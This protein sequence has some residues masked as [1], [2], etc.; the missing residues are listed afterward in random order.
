MFLHKN[1]TSHAKN[2]LTPENNLQRRFQ[3]IH[4][5]RL[6]QNCTISFQWIVIGIFQNFPK[7]SKIFSKTS[8]AILEKSFAMNSLKP[9][10]KIIFRSQNIFCMGSMVFMQKHL[11]RKMLLSEI[12]S[13][14]QIEVGAPFSML[15]FSNFLTF[16]K[17]F[18]H[19]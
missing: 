11:R 6:F 4:S 9:P 3:R 17:P 18:D 10:L 5:K 13:Y 16:W 2:A 15:R 14:A 19:I 7:F 1:H 8:G 12:A